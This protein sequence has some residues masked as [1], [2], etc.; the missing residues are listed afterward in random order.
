M[1]SAICPVVKFKIEAGCEERSIDIIEECEGI[2]ASDPGCLR[3]EIRNASK[4]DDRLFLFEI[5]RD[6]KAFEERKASTIFLARTRKIHA[7]PIDTREI[8][9]SDHGRDRLENRRFARRIRRARREKP[10]IA[11]KRKGPSST[12]SRS[13]I[14][15]REEDH[16]Q[17]IADFGLDH[18]CMIGGYRS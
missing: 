16:R 14:D 18:H 15:I 17:A 6:E 13:I 2:S 9:V 8:H 10:R 4:D 5:H 11:S 3:F 7:D 1:G 12:G